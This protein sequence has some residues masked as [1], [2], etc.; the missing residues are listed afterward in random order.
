MGGRQMI[1]STG[2]CIKTKDFAKSRAFYEGFGFKA[3]FEVGPDKEIKD[4]SNVV[5]FGSE[6][7]G[8]FELTDG[9][10]AIKPSVFQETIESSKISLMFE[11]DSLEEILSLAKKMKLEPAVPVRHYYYG[12]L[13]AVF[14]DPDGT[15]VVF[16]EPYTAELAKKLNASEEF[17]K[18]PLK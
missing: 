9:H 4:K 14:Y 1:K 16:I 7:G 8:N 12:N 10:V 2:V 6:T 17:G 5:I 3:K 15:R 13:E 18:A 11:V